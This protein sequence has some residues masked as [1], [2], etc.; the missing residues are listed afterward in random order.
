V[1]S[2]GLNRFKAINDSLG[3]AVGDELLRH[4]AARVQEVVPQDATF[5][6][7]GGDEF[8]VFIPAIEDK[9]VP[10][11][12]AKA[13]VG[14]LRAVFLV[15]AHSIHVGARI[16]VAVGTDR[17]RDLDELIR[18][19]EAAMSRAK[20]RGKS[21]DELSWQGSERVSERLAM[22]VE[23]RTALARSELTVHFQPVVRAHDGV[24]VGAE[25]LVR[26]HHSRRGAIPPGEIIAVAE[27][28]GVIAE[29]DRYV[30]DTALRYARAWLER[31][32]DG[33]VAINLSAPSFSNPDLPREMQQ[34][35]LDAGV[36]PRRL[37]VEITESR[38]MRDPEASASV[39]HQ[40]K[41]LGVGVALD[42]FGIGYSS[43]AYLKMFPV[44]HLKIDRYFVQGIGLDD[45]DEHLIEVVSELA[46]K[47][48][49]AVLAEGIET[50]EQLVWLRNKRCDLVQG[51]HTGRPVP[52]DEFEQLY[53][54]GEGSTTGV[55]S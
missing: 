36:A 53:V 41:A 16:G 21:V 54:R 4:V 25:A 45:R 51:F 1:L 40:L 17:S 24:V 8:A 14:R 48:G 23:L 6:R 35:L 11:R 55:A 27:E 3:H 50:E 42:D 22:E 12:L 34:A 26:W 15:R 44:D 43:L 20:E 47:R 33:W 38:A 18:A 2:I 19:A 13:I 5:A 39:V 49:I 29:L 28:C 32:W 37:V 46:R 31:G 9:D 30:G 10:R 7:L 52:A